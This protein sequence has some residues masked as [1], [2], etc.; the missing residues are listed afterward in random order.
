MEDILKLSLTELIAEIQ[1]RKVSPVELM[2]A[3]LS[4]IDEADTDLNTVVSM[5]D[6]EALMDDA[7]QS[8]ERIMRGD[9]RPLEG[10]PLGVKDLEDVE[11]LVTSMG[12][13]PFRDNVAERDSTQVERLR[14]AGAIVLGKTNT[15]EF[16][17]IP[18]TTNYVFGTT[19][20]PWNLAHTPG[21]SSGGSS[22][23]IA[24]CILPLATGSDGGGSIRIP[25]S[26]SGT[27]GLK[28]SF[29]RIPKGPMIQWSYSDTSVLG[30]ITKTVE[31]A[32][33]FMDQ[34]I[35]PS[36][37]DPNSLPHPGLSYLDETRKPLEETLR[38]AYSPDLGHAVVQSDVAAAVEE[39]VK[40]FEKLGHRVK[41]IAGGPPLIGMDWSLLG[42]LDS[43]STLLPLLPERER[44]FRRAYIQGVKNNL[45]ITP[46]R[47]V[48]SAIKRNQVNHWCAE[49]FNA[50][51]LLLTPT[52]PYDPPP[53]TGPFPEETE[54]TKQVPAGG[55]VFTIPFNQSWHPAATVRVGLSKIGLPIGLQIVG[56]RHREDMVLRAARAFEAERP[57][58]PDWP[59]SWQKLDE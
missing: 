8:E 11:G 22:A 55:A 42:A 1:Q 12:S 36:T 47:W 28:P 37:Y 4:R 43:A 51:D 50:F 32:S 17:F 53:A 14:E 26:F 18:F 59:T 33:L 25:S 5:R 16:G 29:G 54:G 7:R 31:D 2:E 49:T 56:P 20:S 3:V 27:F 13:I 38:M 24:G 9:I 6:R 21:G 15:P 34:V 58:H 39:G 35:G 30:P 19:R 57:W 23:A 44:D 52:V 45:R 46:E 41:E 40:V 10:I 48:E